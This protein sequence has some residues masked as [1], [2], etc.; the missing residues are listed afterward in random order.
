MQKAHTN[1]AGNLRYSSKEIWH[2][3]SVSEIQDIICKANHVKALGTRHCFNDIANCNAAHISLARLDRIIQLD[4]NNQTVTCEGGVRYG[5]LGEFLHQHGFALSNLAS[6]PHINVAGA[7]A[8]ATHGSGIDNQNLSAAVIAI[9]LVT[10]SGD[11]LEISRQNDEDAFNAYPVHLGALGIVTE[12]TLK[13]EPTFEVRQDLFENLSLPSFLQHSD[14]ILSSAYSVSLFT[15][16]TSDAFHQVWLKSKADQLSS[17]VNADSFF[18]ATP[19]TAKLHPLPNHPAEFCTEQLGTLG[20]WHERLPHFKLEFTPSSGEELQTEYFIPRELLAPA[21]EALFTIR[22]AIQP[23]VFVTELRSIAK[24]K[25]WLSPAYDRDCIGIH[26]T[27]KPEQE[28][29]LHLL[30]LIEKQL[31]PFSPRPHWGKLFTIP[32]SQIENLYPRFSDFRDLVR[33]LDP[34]R[35]FENHYLSAL[36]E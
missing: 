26:F 10:S 16:W 17:H 7:I 11:V 15:D 3:A 25:L 31:A 20:P 5:E 36:F 24:D 13:I 12:L 30:P 32:S 35:K 29:V 6:L 34:K 4:V 33:K 9:K 21:L 28:S 8:T 22:P 19:A 1:W 23:H 2:P 27:W 18:G 14:E